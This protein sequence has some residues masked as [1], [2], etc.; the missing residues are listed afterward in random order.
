MRYQE[1]HRKNKIPL[2]EK[3]I[4]QFLDQL[5]QSPATE[6]NTF[7]FSSKKGAPTLFLRPIKS[8]RKSTPGTWINPPV[9]SLRVRRIINGIDVTDMY[10]KDDT[11]DSLRHPNG[12]K[13][14][15]FKII[16]DFKGTPK[17]GTLT[18]KPFDYKTFKD[19][20]HFQPL[21]LQRK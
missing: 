16:M 11:F 3:K 4:D 2:D 21:Q 12:G 19:F 13:H 17:P 10:D 20:R 8:L 18:P 14:F 9:T 15:D 5:S 6:T 7:Y 1:Y